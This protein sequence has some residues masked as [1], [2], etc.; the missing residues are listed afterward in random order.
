MYH[1]QYWHSS[2]AEWRDAGVRHSDR[3]L[4]ARRMRDDRE[5]CGDSVIFRI[6]TSAEAAALPVVP[7]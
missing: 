7:F 3:T 6:V 5:A 2:A 4:V 1:L